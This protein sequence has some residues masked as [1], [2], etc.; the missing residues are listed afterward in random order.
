MITVYRQIDGHL[1]ASGSALEP[2]AGAVWIDLHE[3]SQDEEKAVEAAISLNIPTRDDMLEIESSSRVYEESGAYYLTA[4]VL[5]S[6]EGREPEL[7]PVTCVLTKERIV[8][9][10]Y[11]APG[12]FAFFA[13]R[14]ATQSL[15]C[16]DGLSTLMALL[17]TIV[18]RLADILEGEGRKLDGT[19]RAIFEAHR[20]SGRMQVLSALMQRIGRAEDMNGKVDESLTTLARLTQYLTFVLSHKDRGA[21]KARLKTLTRDIRSLLEVAAKQERKITFQL[22]ATLGVINIRQADVIKIFSVVAFV[23][24]PP[25]LIASIYGMNFDF[26]PELQWEWGYPAALVAM[27]VS[28][29]VP[30]LLFRWKRWL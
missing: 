21:E 1:V 30:Y 12:S 28:A 15:G 16:A 18:D 19:T 20:P 4:D 29:L 6:P 26:M 8:T 23:F 17:E 24:L 11:H 9:V 22:D 10:R 5:A 7:G 25:T 3:P 14:A 13:K 2:L 27:V